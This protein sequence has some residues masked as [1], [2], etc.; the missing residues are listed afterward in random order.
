LDLGET[1]RDAFDQIGSAGGHAGM[2]GAQIPLG[3]LG[4]SD[5]A[6]LSDIVHDVIT[7][8][9]YGAFD[10]RPESRSDGRSVEIDG[11]AGE[12]PLAAFGDPDD[13]NG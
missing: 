3:L 8:R 5:E 4:E 6:D 1:L 9:F 7:R 2:A 13:P 11:E 10:T 12:D